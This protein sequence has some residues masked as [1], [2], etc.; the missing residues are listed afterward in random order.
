MHVD[1]ADVRRK[2]HAAEREAKGDGKLRTKDA[3]KAG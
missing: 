2:Y 3:E 1:I